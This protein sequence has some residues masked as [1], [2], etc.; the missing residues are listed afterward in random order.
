MFTPL[1]LWSLHLP[2]CHHNLTISITR[3]LLVIQAIFQW[4]DSSAANGWRML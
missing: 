4:L 1:N 2:D 3:W